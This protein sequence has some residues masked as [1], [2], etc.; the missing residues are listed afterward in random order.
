MIALMTSTPTSPPDA[1]PAAP[2][3]DDGTSIRRSL[4]EPA[5][6][7]VIYERHHDPVFRYVASR[8]GFEHAEDVVGEVFLQAF[9]SRSKF[10]ASM[11]DTALPWLLGIATRRISRQRDAQRRWI[12]QCAATVEHDATPN[13]EDRVVGRADASRLAPALADAIAQLREQDR[14]PLLLHVVGGL[15]YEE[16][17]VA[18][19]IP[20]G[21]VRSRISRARTRLAGILDGVER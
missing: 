4:R 5:V 8:L 16:V 1:R 21:T 2:A 10:D 13:D 12:A 7:D 20:V 9:A 11:C 3:G 17:A 19:A 6:F 18:L 15:A 14:E